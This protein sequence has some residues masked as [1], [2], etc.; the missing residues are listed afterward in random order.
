MKGNIFR[1]IKPR[2]LRDLRSN[3]ARALHSIAHDAIWKIFGNHDQ[4]KELPLSRRLNSMKSSR[5]I[6]RVRSLY[7]TDVSRTISV[8]IIRLPTFRGPSR[9]LSSGLPSSLFLSGFPTKILYVLHLSQAC[10]INQPL[11]SQPPWYDHPNIACWREQIMGL[12]IMQFSPF[13]YYFSLLGPRILLSTLFSNILNLCPSL[14]GRDQ[15]S[16]PY[17][18]TGKFIFL[19]ILNFKLFERR[20]G[21]ERLW[22]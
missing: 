5:A 13:S 14:S 9:S 20:R 8:I 11:P 4:L 21:T 16:R 10:S 15:V 17:K 6:S 22:T 18:T 3:S 1:V 19:C 7:E 2:N 12:F